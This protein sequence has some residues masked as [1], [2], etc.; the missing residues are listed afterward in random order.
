MALTEAR[1]V[2]TT[3]GTQTSALPDL[4]EVDALAAS[5]VYGVL[6]SVPDRIA[7]F[8]RGVTTGI[9]AGDLLAS[10]RVT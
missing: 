10:A 9:D 6:P 2:V 4:F 3:K 1:V 7:C 8:C 5:A